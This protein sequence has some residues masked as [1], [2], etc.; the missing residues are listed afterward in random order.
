M[1]VPPLRLNPPLTSTVPAAPV[2]VAPVWVKPALKVCV[3]VFAR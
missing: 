3:P 1:N 2:N